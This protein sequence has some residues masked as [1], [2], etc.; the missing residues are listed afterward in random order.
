MQKDR[1]PMY[2]CERNLEYS[3]KVNVN[4]TF[5]TFNVLNGLVF[6]MDFKVMDSV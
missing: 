1:K 4:V 2:N 6:V 5:N 3:I